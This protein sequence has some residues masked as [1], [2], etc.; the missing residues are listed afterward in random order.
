MINFLT[1]YSLVLLL[2][3]SPTPCSTSNCRI[4]PIWQGVRHELFN[5]KCGFLG[6]QE[7]NTFRLEDPNKDQYMADGQDGDTDVEV[8][9]YRQQQRV[10]GRA[11]GSRSS[12]R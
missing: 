7:L 6:V 8:G 1:L 4:P 3:Y 11:R 2:S 5:P 12:K 10:S 9:N